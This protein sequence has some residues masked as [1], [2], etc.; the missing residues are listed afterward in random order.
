MPVYMI[1]TCSWQSL[2]EVI[3][4][5]WDSHCD[6]QDTRISRGDGGSVFVLVKDV[7][8]PSDLPPSTTAIV[9]IADTPQ[10]S[11]TAMT[12]P[13]PVTAPAPTT[14]PAP[15]TAPTPSAAPA[16]YLSVRICIFSCLHPMPCRQSN[17]HAI[18]AWAYQLPGRT[19]LWPRGFSCGT[20]LSTITC[21]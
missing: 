6:L 11:S 16:P 1:G 3:E 15:A 4:V 13:A 14:A 17:A 21:F 8:F 12:T 20:F 18:N 10:A 19:W 9:P 5:S 7:S 2:G